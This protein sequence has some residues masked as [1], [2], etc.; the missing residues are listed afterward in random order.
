MKYNKKLRRLFFLCMKKCKK[1][2]SKFCYDGI[3]KNTV[4]VSDGF[5]I[6]T[7]DPEILA[8]KILYVYENY[9][10]L[11]KKAI[12]FNDKIIAEKALWSAN[13]AIV[14]SKYREFCQAK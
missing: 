6:P 1:R 8:N 4:G 5:L 12:P 9:K 13:M 10:E 7:G 11:E 3:I 2:I 14:E